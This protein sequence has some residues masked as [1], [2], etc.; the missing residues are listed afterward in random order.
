MKKI[1]IGATRSKG[2][3]TTEDKKE[4]VFDNIVLT[5]A[6]YQGPNTYFQIGKEPDRIKIHTSDFEDVTGIKPGHFLA[7][8]SDFI[9]KKV[10]VGMMLNDYDKAE[11]TSIR[12]DDQQCYQAFNADAE[13]RAPRKSLSEEDLG[14]GANGELLVDVTVPFVFAEDGEGGLRV[15]TATGE[16]PPDFDI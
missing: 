14:F 7:H 10:K 16:V 2:N 3:I 13:A 5:F 11:V 6:D 12:F 4:I 15:D 9:F 8:L 1:L